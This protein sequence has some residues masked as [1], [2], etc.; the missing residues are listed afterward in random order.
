MALAG[1]P[2]SYDHPKIHEMEKDG[3]VS[4][5]NYML[6]KSFGE[7][8]TDYVVYKVKYP[9]S[10]SPN[11]EYT[12]YT[13]VGTTLHGPFSYVKHFQEGASGAAI[14]SGQPCWTLVYEVE[15]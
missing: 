11:T 12:I 4:G 14:N 9:N 1:Y 6:I 13:T 2:K 3:E 7:N 5:G 10:K 15:D 8:S